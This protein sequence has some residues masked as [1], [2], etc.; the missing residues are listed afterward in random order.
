M[1]SF[2]IET[3]DIHVTDATA[4]SPKPQ[5][6]ARRLGLTVPHEWWPSAHLLKSFEA[7]G[8]AWAQVDAPPVDVLRTPRLVVRHAVALGESLHSTGLRA[9]L[10]APPGARAGT[11]DGDRVLESLISYAA[12][13][14]A[15]Q[16]VYHALALPDEPPS[17]DGL[18]LEERS[19]AHL[20]RRA[21][22]LN[23]GI[24]VENLA[25]MYPGIETLSANPLSLRSLV[26]RLGTEGVGICL[27]LGHAHIVAERRKTSLARFVEPVLDV[28][29]LFHIHDN[30]GARARLGGSTLSVDPL[31][32]DLHLPPG[33]GSLPWHT[34]SSLVS[35]HDAPVVLEVHPPFRR[36]A[37][38]LR[39]DAEL[40][41]T[42]D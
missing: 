23:I 39:E 30:L 37:E 24:C 17:E 8:F 41:L 38:E 7:A 28:V 29:T 22:D 13:A 35:G 31:R 36:G 2:R 18:R 20:A 16:I 21:A 12:E 11:R 6:M 3:S 34:V 1:E 32:L 40:L 14:G 15:E 19:L 26:H 25:P 4:V 10:H 9:V 42:T 27:D 33:R 5:A